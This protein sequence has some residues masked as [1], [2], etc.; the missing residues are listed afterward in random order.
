MHHAEEVGLELAAP[1]V[2]R[3]LLDGP[4]EAE[5][6]VV[7]ERPDRALRALDLRDRGPA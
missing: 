2:E 6:G 4:L 3:Y 5:A 7:D 1:L